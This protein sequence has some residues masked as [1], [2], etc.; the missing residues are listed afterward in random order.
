MPKLFS[1]FKK[2]LKRQKLIYK[3]GEEKVRKLISAATFSTT[4]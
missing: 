2:K 3:A 4:I 1:L